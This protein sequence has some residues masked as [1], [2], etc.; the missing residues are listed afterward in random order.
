MLFGYRADLID[1]GAYAK[2]RLIGQLMNLLVLG[3]IISNVP[4]S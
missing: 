3:V 4:S 2:G 1:A